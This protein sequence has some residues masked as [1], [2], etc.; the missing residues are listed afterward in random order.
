MLHHAISVT[1]KKLYELNLTEIYIQWLMLSED[2][3]SKY[4]DARKCFTHCKWP[5]NADKDMYTVELQW[6]EPRWLVYHGWVEHV[7]ESAG[8]SSK[9]DI[10]II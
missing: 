10:R 3:N 2:T 7:L 4:G 5:P 6:L 8:I 9:Y 1:D